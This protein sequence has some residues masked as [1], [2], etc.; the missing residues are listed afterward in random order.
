MSLDLQGLTSSYRVQSASP[1]G[2]SG[3][4][5]LSTE[6]LER[7]LGAKEKHQ[8]QTVLGSPFRPGPGIL[9]A[10]VVLPETPGI[11]CLNPKNEGAAGSPGLKTQELF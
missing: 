10:G 7:T 2:P 8:E 11:L 3:H 9:W 1:F 5:A 4:S 6:Q